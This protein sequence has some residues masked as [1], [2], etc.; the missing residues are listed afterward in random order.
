MFFTFTKIIKAFDTEILDF[1]VDFKV[2]NNRTSMKTLKA[3]EPTCA[4][5]C[6]IW[7]G[8]PMK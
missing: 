8:N 6:N 7:Q 3:I 5:L 4:L 1:A 2:E